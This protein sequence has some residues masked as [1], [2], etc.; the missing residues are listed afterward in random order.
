MNFR[1]MSPTR[2]FFGGLALLVL[3]VLVGTSPM[4]VENVDAGKIVVIQMPFSGR[5]VWYTTPGLKWQWWGKVTVYDKQSQFWFS[6]SPDQGDKKDESIPVRFNDKGHANISGSLSWQMPADIEHLTQLHTRYN[7]QEAIEHNLI[8]TVVEKAVY[9][10]GPLMSSQESAAERRNELLQYIEDQVANGV[11]RTET[12]QEKQPDPVS[13]Q[14]RTVSIVRLVIKNGQ[15]VRSD[16]SPLAMFG[17]RTFNPSINQIK[18]DAVVEAQIAE[19]QKATMAVQTSLAN[20][21]KAEQDAITAAKNGEAEAAKAKWQQEVL[22][23]TAVTEAQQKLAVA[24]LDRKTAEQRKQEQILLG[25]GEAKRRQLVMSADGALDKKLAAYVETQKAWAD[26]FAR[27]PGQLVPTI[28]YGSDGNSRAA[29][30]AQDFM[31]IMGAKA[32]RDLAIDLSAAGN[33][34]TKKK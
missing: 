6:A 3:L 2:L 33:D 32:A 1:D 25:E 7:S 17:I 20:Y 12:I 8:R 31:N 30:G 26:A 16:E 28:V 21:K 18:Y 5:L 19:Q 13:G 11:Y 4:I 15:I 10:T 34:K 23:A 9:M 27:F 14:L 24:E 22:K 29:S